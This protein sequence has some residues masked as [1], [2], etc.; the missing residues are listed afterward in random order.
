VS[1]VGRAASSD[2]PVQGARA[3]TV[4]SRILVAVAPPASFVPSPALDAAVLV[5]ASPASPAHAVSPSARRSIARRWWFWAALGTAAVGAVVAGL[6]LGPRQPYSGNAS[7]G[8][9]TAF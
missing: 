7:P 6:V 9:L 5:G 1:V 2:S 3:A 4:S 8:I